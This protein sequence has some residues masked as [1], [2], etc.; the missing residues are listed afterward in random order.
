MCYKLAYFSSLFDKGFELVIVAGIVQ[1]FF[2]SK[3][4]SLS[5]LK[6]RLDRVAS[7]VRVNDDDEIYHDSV[8]DSLLARY[9]SAT[10]NLDQTLIV[11]RTLLL[12]GLLPPIL[13]QFL[14]AFESSGFVIPLQCDP[15]VVIVLPLIISLGWGPLTAFYFGIRAQR[16]C[17]PLE[18]EYESQIDRLIGAAKP[19]S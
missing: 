18:G 10:E 3:K 17:R 8:R 15:G 4:F 19:I 11:C 9:E 1:E 13:F 6:D 14:L 2:L 12:L 16:I 5:N 7:A